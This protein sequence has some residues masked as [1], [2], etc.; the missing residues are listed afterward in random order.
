M[1]MVSEERMAELV[2]AEKQRDDAQ[3]V[4]KWI[5][6][7]QCG[8]VQKSGEHWAVRFYGE[9]RWHWGGS[10]AM[11]IRAALGLRPSSPSPTSAGTD[12][13]RRAAQ[14]LYDRI[15][16]ITLDSRLQGQAHQDPDAERFTWVEAVAHVIRQHVAAPAQEPAALVN[17]ANKT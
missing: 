17:V 16:G 2:A 14:E 5:H 11:A 6:S 3:A 15:D 12:P 4:L 9:D 13:A 7:H 8:A 10:L 1:V